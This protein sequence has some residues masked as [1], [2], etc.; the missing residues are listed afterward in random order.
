MIC[1]DSPPCHFP[2]GIG[3]IVRS[4]ALGRRMLVVDVHPSGTVTCAWPDG[5]VTFAAS[6]LRLERK[7]DKK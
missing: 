5:E 6:V 2:F 7:A 1:V 4:S 3:D